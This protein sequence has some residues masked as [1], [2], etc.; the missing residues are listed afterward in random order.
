[1]RDPNK[2]QL[3]LYALPAG[4]TEAA[5]ESEGEIDDDEDQRDDADE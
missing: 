4:V 5:A 3:R 2:A 1:V